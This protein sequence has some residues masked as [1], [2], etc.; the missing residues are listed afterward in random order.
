M[1]EKDF[2]KVMAA[3]SE[4]K[5]SLAYA[6]ILRSKGYVFDKTKGQSSQRPASSGYQLKAINPGGARSRSQEPEFL[7]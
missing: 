4:E 3:I 2:L 5:Y 1:N 7:G 6:L